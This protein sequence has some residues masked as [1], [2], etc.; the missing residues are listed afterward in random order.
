[1]MSVERAESGS[2][3]KLLPA[4]KRKKNILN[5]LQTH[6]TI[7][8]FICCGL[9]A[10]TKYMALKDLKSLREEGRIVRLGRPAN[11]QYALAKGV[12]GE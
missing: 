8:S 5:Y 3:L 11:A 10:C 7:T 6:Q 2:R 4:D 12:E 1:M 9:N